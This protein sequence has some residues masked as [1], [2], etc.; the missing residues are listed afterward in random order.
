MKDFKPT[1]TVG[2]THT[3]VFNIIEIGGT[4]LGALECFEHLFSRK[5][6]RL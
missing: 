6:D 1:T 2:A 3:V 4:A 5:Y